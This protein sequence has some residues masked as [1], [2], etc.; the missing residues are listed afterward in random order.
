MPNLPLRTVKVERR[1][2]QR[3]CPND[4]S[5]P[6]SK[7]SHNGKQG[8]QP[9]AYAIQTQAPGRRSF[10]QRMRE[11]RSQRNSSRNNSSSTRRNNNLGASSQNNNAT[12]RNETVGV[13]TRNASAGA[14]HVLEMPNNSDGSKNEPPMEESESATIEFANVEGEVSQAQ[15][16]QYDEDVEHN[17]AVERSSLK[18]IEAQI[19]VEAV[20]EDRW[21]VSYRNHSVVIAVIAKKDS[22]SNLL[23]HDRKTQVMTTFFSA[24]LIALIITLT[25]TLSRKSSPLRLSTFVQTGLNI[26]GPSRDFP[27]GSGEDAM[28]GASISMNR[29]GTRIAIG[30]PEYTSSVDGTS[31]RGLIQIFGDKNGVTQEEPSSTKK[32]DYAPTNWTLLESILGESSG[33]MAGTSVALSLDGKY[34]VVGSPG[35]SIPISPNAE[36]VQMAGKVQVYREDSQGKWVQIGQPIVSED[37][38]DKLGLSVAISQDGSRIAI[39]LQGNNDRNSMGKARVYEYIESENEWFQLG[40][41]LIGW[42]G[43]NPLSMSADGNVVVMGS[44]S[45]EENQ[46]VAVVSAYEYKSGWKRMGSD[47]RL[48]G[49]IG[50]DTL[51]VPSL[52]SDGRTFAVGTALLN[53]ENMEYH[54]Y[55][56]VYRYKDEG[57]MGDWTQMGENLHD[58]KGNHLIAYTVSLSADGNVLVIGD[59]GSSKNGINSGHTHVMRNVNDGW[60]ETENKLEG[61]HPSDLFG[62][63]V[64]VSPNGK[65]VGISSPQSRMSGSELGAV[66]IYETKALD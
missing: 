54:L 20:E 19:V 25:V 53:V 22:F 1:E 2:T 4:T 10:L 57:N 38:N 39:S 26:Q 59:P 3:V 18:P 52:S 37:M 16:P 13:I 51:F 33:D 61:F 28:F 6:D 60:V 49:G 12:R 32:T 27:F 48:N 42:L 17:T 11:M 55:V 31:F 14:F 23:R 56:Q 58:K 45:T 62:W 64:S 5:S 50:Y 35:H 34:V 63:S 40:D 43:R 44:V 36:L 8:P 65:R 29:D 46:Y 21:E 47:I 9:G 7:Y 24:S 30:A 15:E 41:D 66:T